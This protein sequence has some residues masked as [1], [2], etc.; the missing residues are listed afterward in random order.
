V[1]N[2]VIDNRNPLPKFRSEEGFGIA[3]SL[4]RKSSLCLPT[5]ARPITAIIP[6]VPCGLRARQQFSPWRYLEQ[7]P[8]LSV[9]AIFVRP[10]P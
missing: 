3:S 1:T 10:S 6:M 4:A 9:G 2:F 8:K 5:G 7:L